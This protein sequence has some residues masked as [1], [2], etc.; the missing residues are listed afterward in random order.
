MS[1][2]NRHLLIL[3]GCNFPMSTIVIVWTTRKVGLDLITLPSH[4]SHALQ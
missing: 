4:T 2:E 3:D 1:M